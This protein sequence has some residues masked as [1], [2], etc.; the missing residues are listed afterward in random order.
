MGIAWLC[1]GCNKGGT[2][3]QNREKDLTK[4]ESLVRPFGIDCIFLTPHF[5]ATAW[6]NALQLEESQLVHKTSW[7][8]LL[9]HDTCRGCVKRGVTAAGRIFPQEA[10]DRLSSVAQRTPLLQP[11][12]Q[13]RCTEAK[14]RRGRSLGLQSSTYC[15]LLPTK[16]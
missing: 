6:S 5:C 8:R 16:R 11:A 15:S 9:K 3:Q 1:A 2:E 12:N 4:R 13:L 7:P 10:P 14:C